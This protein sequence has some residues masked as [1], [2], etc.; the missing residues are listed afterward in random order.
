[1]KYSDFLFEL[2][3]EELP[4]KA[5]SALSEA[6][7]VN[8]QEGFKKANIQHADIESFGSP[9]RMAVLVKDVANTQDKQKVSRRGPAVAGSLDADNNPK[10][11]LMGFARSCGVEISE[12]S[13]VATPKGD[14]WI[15]EAELEGKPTQDLLLDIVQESLDK[16]PIAKLMT[17]GDAKFNFVRPVHWA[18][19]LFGDEV[20]PGELF[21]VKTGRES[22]GHRFHH[23][24][25]VS[26]D[27]PACYVDTLHAVKVVSSFAKRRSMILE[28]LHELAARHSL[29]AI[30][31]DDLLDEV[32][33]IVEWPNAILANFAPEF[34][35]VPEEAIIA[36]L[37]QHQK[38]F[39]LKDKQ[40]KLS[41]HFITVA[42]I[43]SK[44]PEKVIA[45][46]EK[47]VKA[48]LSDAAFFYEQDAKQPLANYALGIDKVVFHAKLGSLADKVQ[49]MTKIMHYLAPHLN[50]DLKLAERASLLAK[51]D[52]LTGMVGEFPELQGIMGS[53]YAANDGESPEVAVAIKDHYYPRFAA[54]ELPGSAYGAALSIADRVDNLVGLFAIKQKPTGVKDPFKL[55]RHALALVRILLNLQ[56]ELSLVD[57]IA[58][59]IDT[60]SEVVAV[61]KQEVTESLITFIF[62]RM[63]SYYQT[64]GIE[65]QFF[66]AVKA[67]QSQYLADM[68]S[69][70]QALLH[71]KQIPEAAALAAA[72]KRVD[73]ILAN[74]KLDSVN[75]QI[76]EELLTEAAEQSLFT[77]ML[78][79]EKT[80]ESL[81]T[82]ND[83]QGVLSSLASIKQPLDDFFT[84]VMVMADDEQIK[85]NR[86][87]LLVRLQKLLKTVA[88]IGLINLQ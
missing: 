5:V 27:S 22:Y 78:D 18:V 57:L 66:L 73:N 10:P 39:A 72:C 68:D 38:C 47:V 88:D 4:S 43:V 35:E 55:R 45:G 19:M 50:L 40:G 6:L 24:E 65:S 59:S 69:R 32:T 14:W 86:L 23:P 58:A 25:A 85:L 28:Q 53:Y 74:A 67:Q 34:L 42:N 62:D 8:I 12:L 61:D 2:G 87:Q 30:I 7:A 84:N 3:V 77:N 33:S 20:I 79:L 46:N 52:L 60:Y 49:R 9:R 48:R 15:Y 36:S 11:S 82:A 21:A 83:Y 29:T 63:Q 31:P 37:Q 81:Q 70:I 80:V 17:W 16:L 54:D 51:C 56:Q 41:P 64:Q 71:F 26:I 76:S 1:M 44:Q 75:P 13:K